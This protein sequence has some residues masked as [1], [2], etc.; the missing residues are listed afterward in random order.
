MAQAIFDASDLLQKLR[1]AS[2]MLV[3]ATRAVSSD[4]GD[5]VIKRVTRG[6][7]YINRTGKMSASV[8]YTPSEDGG[9]VTASAKH[10]S[11]LDKGTKPHKITARRAKA[12]RFVSRSGGVVFARSVNH[13]GTK[14]L[15]FS[16]K[17]SEFVA[18]AFEDRMTRA[19]DQV[20]SRSGLA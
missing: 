15:D 10:A 9:K 1:G 4:I 17:E 13:P 20:I 14:A 7:Y 18:V 5:D 3:T 16:G 6:L 19:I 2:T 8:R 11:M 12:L